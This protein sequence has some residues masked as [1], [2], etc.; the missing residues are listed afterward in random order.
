MFK[1]DFK[2]IEWDVDGLL[3]KLVEGGELVFKSQVKKLKKDW[4]RQKKLYE[5]YFVKFGGKV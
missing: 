3:I 5:E 4:D 2:Y 1:D